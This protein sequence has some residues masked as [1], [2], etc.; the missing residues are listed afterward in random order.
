MWRASLR[1]PVAV[2][3]ILPGAS[4]DLCYFSSFGVRGFPASSISVVNFYPAAA[5]AAI[6]QIFVLVNGDGLRDIVESARYTLIIS[7]DQ[8]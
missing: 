3:A 6:R 7:I 5:T 2:S 8:L 4:P 1:Y